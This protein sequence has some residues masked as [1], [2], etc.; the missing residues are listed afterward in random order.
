MKNM[1]GIEKIQ[2]KIFV[3]NGSTKKMVTAFCGGAANAGHQIT[4]RWTGS[5]ISKQR[6][7]PH[8]KR[9]FRA[10]ILY[11]SAGVFLHDSP[12]PS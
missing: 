6:C 2:M 8:G 11:A 10:D 4:G 7:N 5:A 9:D 12:F 3:L 1:I